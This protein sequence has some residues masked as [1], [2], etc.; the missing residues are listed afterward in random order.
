MSLDDQSMTGEELYKVRL[1]HLYRTMGERN[2][3]AEKRKE[4]TESS[5]DAPQ[6]QRDYSIRIVWM[7]PHKTIFET[8][9]K[10]LYNFWLDL[11]IPKKQYGMSN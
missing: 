6:S 4:M 7:H 10:A 8:L 5:S 11:T 1:Q 3:L 2:K 9:D